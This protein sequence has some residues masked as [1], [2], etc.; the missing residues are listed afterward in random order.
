MYVLPRGVRW[1]TGRN[2]AELG[3]ELGTQPRSVSASTQCH[4]RAPESLHRTKPKTRHKSNSPTG[5]RP[6]CRLGFLSVL[7]TGYRR[8]R[9]LII[10]LAP[11]CATTSFHRSDPL[12]SLSGWDRRLARRATRPIQFAIS[13]QHSNSNKH[14]CRAAGRRL[15]AP[16]RPTTTT[17]TKLIDDRS[18]RRSQGGGIVVAHA[19]RRLA[20]GPTIGRYVVLTALMN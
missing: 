13:H 2:A 18:D 10:T 20:R 17:T 1:Y 6:S 8:R 5:T 3:S 4:V 19:G 11:L 12:L 16:R 15:V 14:W 9:Y 7:L